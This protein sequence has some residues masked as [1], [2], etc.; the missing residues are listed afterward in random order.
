MNNLTTQFLGNKAG[1]LREMV[2]KLDGKQ[3][4]TVLVTLIKY[5]A[6]CYVAYSCGAEGL[7]H[8]SVESV[9]NVEDLSQ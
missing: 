1:L 4:T 2:N 9:L 3:L 8:L 7:K 5:G 6:I